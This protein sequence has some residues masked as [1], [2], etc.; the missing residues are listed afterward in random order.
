MY[1]VVSTGGKQLKVEEGT[2]A[3]VEKLD[4]PVGDTVKLDVLF[5]ADDGQIV[6]DADA[7]TKA[8]RSE[9]DPDICHDCHGPG[10]THALGQPWLDSDQADYHGNQPQ[11]NCATCHDLSADCNQCHFGATGSKSPP[12]SGWPHGEK[13][14]HNDQEKYRQVCIQCHTLTQAYRNEPDDPH[15]LTCH[16]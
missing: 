5:V 10:T 15:C 13:D 6:A 14:N 7:L 1:A 9:P 11:E 16:D 4:A 8:Y 3:V 2:E 12:G